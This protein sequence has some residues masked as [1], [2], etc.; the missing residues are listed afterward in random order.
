MEATNKKYTPFDIR[1]FLS[2]DVLCL[3]GYVKYFDIEEPEKYLELLQASIDRLP[4]PSAL[5]RFKD[6]SA[7][8]RGFILASSATDASRGQMVGMLDD[9]NRLI[10]QLS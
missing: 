5:E 8:F 7:Y 3:R 2:R 10:K 6:L 1:K 4:D 9:M